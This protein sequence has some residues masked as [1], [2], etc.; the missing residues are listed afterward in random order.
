MYVS[1]IA[2]NPEHIVLFGY[3]FESWTISETIQ[4]NLSIL[5]GSRKDLNVNIDTRY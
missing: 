1:D 4:R 2:F 5:K 3:S